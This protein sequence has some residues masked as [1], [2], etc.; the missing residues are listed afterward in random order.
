MIVNLN[1]RRPKEE[2]LPI[3]VGQIYYFGASSSPELVIITDITN[4]NKVKY[5]IYPYKTDCSIETKIFRNLAYTGTNCW[6]KSDNSKYHSKQA[7]EFLN[8]LNHGILGTFY[9]PQDL[10]CVH[11][12]I[13]CNDETINDP[14]SDL[15]NYRFFAHSVSHQI[16]DILILGW[17]RGELNEM[18]KALPEYYEIVKIEE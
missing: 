7:I 14:W 8:M 3:A 16:D 10:Q 11:V 1:A 4:P 6:L 12:S 15:E 13:R 9:T 2:K 18:R 5:R 17:Q